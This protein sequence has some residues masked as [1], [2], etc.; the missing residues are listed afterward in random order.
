[1]LVSS[2]GDV[3]GVGSEEEL[4]APEDRGPEAE[5]GGGGPEGNAADGGR[6]GG[7]S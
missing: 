4:P 2:L 3:G 1:M 6:Y 7:C 5:N